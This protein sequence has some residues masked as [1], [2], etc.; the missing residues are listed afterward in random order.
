VKYFLIYTSL[1]L[2]LFA[3]CTAVVGG[4]LHLFIDDVSQVWIW[5]LVGGAVTSSAL[6][7]KLLAKPRA[8]FAMN[9]QQRAERATKAFDALKAS[10]DAD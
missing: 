8:G 4:L 7:L 6:S 9:V 5:A 10:E 1:R 3:A 2:L